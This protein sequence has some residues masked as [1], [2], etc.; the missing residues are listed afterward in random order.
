[1]KQN[2][3][4]LSLLPWILYG[5]MPYAWRNALSIELGSRF[6][7]EIGPIPVSVP[8]S[9][10]QALIDANIIPDWR[11]DLNTRSIEWIENRHWIYS[12]ELPREY[13]SQGTYILECR[14][15]DH[16][17]WIYMNSTLVGTFSNSF[18]PCRFPITE[19]M[20]QEHNL[21]RII[22]REPPRWLGQLGYTSRIRDWKPRFYYTWDWV[23]RVV[24]TAITAPVTL[25]SAES[26][27]FDIRH[28]QCTYDHASGK[29]NVL[30]TVTVAGSV[31]RFTGTEQLQV[32][33]EDERGNIIAQAADSIAGKSIVMGLEHVAVAAWYPNRHGGQPLYRLTIRLID[34]S[35][36]SCWE[37]EKQ[38][39]FKEIAWLP[40]AGGPKGATPWIC[41]VNGKKIF[42]QGVNWTPISPTF[43]DVP[44]AEVEK[45][46]RLYK[47][48]GCNLL[49]IWGGAV[50]ETEA[51][52]RECD[53]LGL[54]IWQE[55][56]LSSSGI[57][58]WPP[59]DTDLIEDIVRIAESYICRRM[60]HVS[61]LMYSGGNE[62]Q[63]SADGSK[64]GTGK[65]VDF[66]HPMMTR[67]RVLFGQL[68]PQ[69]RFIPTSPFGPRFKADRDEN[70]L[71]LHWS[72]HGPWNVDRILDERW[73][74]Y[75]EEDDSLFRAETGCPGAMDTERLR[76]YV[77]SLSVFPIEQANPVWGRTSW[78][79]ETDIFEAE[80]GR[81]P[82]SAEEYC[83]WSQDRQAEALKIAVGKTKKRFPASGGII[84]WMGHDCYPCAANTSIIDVDG[85]PKPAYYTLKEIF[86]AEKVA[87]DA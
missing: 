7:P 10:Q 45:R 42:L 48:M 52:Y 38:I 64:T 11:Y 79:I 69:R 6:E 47:E 84:I 63:G 72:V 21:L 71:G 32:S 50:L 46:L 43:A 68:D 87:E 13:D 36:I 5:T 73:A 12:C 40:C 31:E 53:R 23:P 15:L 62:L 66:T 27:S 37:K 80:F 51:F 61:L 8:G 3:L 78:W 33:L 1:M 70:N 9:V 41:Q 67:L 59:E 82:F 60:H 86:T 85:I 29:G 77:P 44:F 81:R 83:K 16:A 30:V 2:C 28:V 65:P 74:A 19:E 76:S 39:G 55:L 49:R 22:F 25:R 20:L 56:P 35:G 54:M 18:V 4:D 24:Q 14:G 34:S 75:W 17:G 26:L 57:D 58:N